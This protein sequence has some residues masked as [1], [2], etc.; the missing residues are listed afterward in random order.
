MEIESECDDAV[1]IPD[2][3]VDPQDLDPENLVDDPQSVG[4]QGKRWCYTSFLDR[5]DPLFPDAECRYRIEGIEVCPTTNR[6]HIQGFVLFNKNYRFAALKKLY[7]SGVRFAFCHGSPFQNFR[8][9]SKEGNFSEYGTRPKDDSSKKTT[10]SNRA[11]REAL[12]APTVSLG[13]EIIR[14]QRPRDYCLYYDAIERSLKRSKKAPFE[15]VY[16]SDDFC[17]GLQVLGQNS[18]LLSGRSGIGKTHYALA[19]FKCPLL[20]SHIDD[21][22][23]LSPDH[24]GIVFDDMSFKH[25]P[26]EGVIHLVDYELERSIH[27]RYGTITIP[28]HTHKIFTHNTLNPF[29]NEGMVNSDQREAI[30]RRVISLYFDKLFT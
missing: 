16:S 19:H 8:Y 3:Y 20:V 12:E 24:D 27:C 30:E 25:M 9:C 6:R 29:Y 11:Y 23:K 5:N 17:I 21:L 15:H 18:L 26:I 4:K 7:P 22:K 10:D 14:Q 13:M 1:P 28:A 2:E